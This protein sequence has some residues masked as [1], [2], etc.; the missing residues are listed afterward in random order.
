M[1]VFAYDASPDTRGRCAHRSGLRSC[2]CGTPRHTPRRAAFAAVSCETQSVEYFRYATAPCWPATLSP[3]FGGVGLVA[4]RPCHRVGFRASAARAMARKSVS[5]RTRQVPSVRSRASRIGL[6]GQSPSNTA[7]PQSIAEKWP[8]QVR[9]RPLRHSVIYLGTMMPPETVVVGADRV[10]I[11]P[12]TWKSRSLPASPQW[13]R[14]RR[15]C[16]FR[17]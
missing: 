6:S 2:L 1:R 4:G 15:R 13:S 7:Q 5:R 3:G 16:R 14:L 10:V 12:K 11:I 8:I 9:V 17:Q